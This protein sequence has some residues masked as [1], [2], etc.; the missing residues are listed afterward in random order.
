MFTGLIETIGTIRTVRPE[1]EGRSFIV[2]ARFTGEPLQVGESIAVDGVC[3]TVESFDAGS[4]RCSTSAETLRRSSLGGKQVGGKVHLER[5]LRLGDRLGGHL[6]QGHVDATGVVR[7]VIPR[8]AG[9]DLVVE[10][11]ETLRPYVV[12]KGSLAVQGVSL[13]VA[14]IPGGKATFALIPETL[15]R[16]YLAELRSGEA[17]NLEA[18][19]L[20]KYV[21]NLLRRRE[22]GVD[23]NTLHEWGFE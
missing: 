15:R 20:A 11:P 19:V 18:D 12:E 8:G 22:G 21:E 3:L 7:Q 13:T 4:F 1:V 6:V 17:V 5:A 16:T 9:A 14:A 10:I 2:A 23:E